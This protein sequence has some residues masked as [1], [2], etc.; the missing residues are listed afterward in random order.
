MR[1]LFRSVAGKKDDAVRGLDEGIRRMG[2]LVTLE[3]SAIDLE[4]QLKRY[5]AALAR[6]DTV[7]S[8]LQRKESWLVRRA[9][10]LKTAGREQEAKKSYR[11]ALAAIEKLPP[12]HRHTRATLQLEASI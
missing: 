11:D 3:L 6:V 12:T 4:V 10:I 5:D 1:V 8:R 7:M 9:E 2:P